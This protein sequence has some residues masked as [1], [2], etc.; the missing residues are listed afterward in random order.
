MI[1]AFDTYYF[2]DYANTIC[3][4]FEDWNSENEAEIFS[5]KTSIISEYESGAFYKRSFPV[6]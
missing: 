5:E 2:E 6:F 4:A 1:Y 3:I